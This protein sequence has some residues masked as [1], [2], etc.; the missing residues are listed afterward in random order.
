MI[1][2]TF[3]LFMYIVAMV[4]IWHLSHDWWV[5]FWATVP[6]VSITKE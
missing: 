3:G 2:P 6:S 1:R 5:L 4:V